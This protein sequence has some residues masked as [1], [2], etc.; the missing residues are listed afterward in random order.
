[1]CGGRGTRLGGDAEKPLVE[2]ADVPM[3]ARVLRALEE[4]GVRDVHAVVSPDT[5]ETEAFLRARAEEPSDTTF[6]VRTGTGEGYVEDLDATLERVGTPA[7]T[8]VA[9]LP[10]LRSAHVDDAIAD[11]GGDSLVVCVPAALKRELGVSTDT[12]FDHE[13]SE[14][15]PTGLNVVGDETDSADRIVVRRDS[16]LG[17]N[18][19][20]P[21]DLA[22]ARDRS[23]E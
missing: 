20:R 14:V 4:S 16:D 6:H 7:V 19:N 5:P 23:S 22:I 17:I 18:V 9:D 10:F 2:V 8:V 15:A 13:G 21:D 11:A 3:V 1:M 12:T